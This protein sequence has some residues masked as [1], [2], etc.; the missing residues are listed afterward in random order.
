MFFLLALF[1]GF[2]II[3]SQKR[4]KWIKENWLSYEVKA[5]EDINSLAK[6][7]DVSW[8]LLVKVNK[9]KPPYACQMGEKIQVPPKK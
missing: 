4:K 3:L 5:G 2:L 8:K 7:F 6:Q 1:G 9:L